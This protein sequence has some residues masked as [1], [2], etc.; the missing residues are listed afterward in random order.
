MTMTE[1]NP[2]DLYDISSPHAPR[3]YAPNPSKARLALSFKG[4]PF[5]TK[6]VDILDIPETRQGLKCP[7]TR[8]LDDGSDF[9]TLPI[10][11]NPV[12]GQTI[13]D[14]FDIA[15]YLD[16]TFPASSDADS[17]RDLFP[18]DSPVTKAILSYN[19]PAADTPF[20]APLTHIEPASEL[21]AA[22]A[23]FNRHVDAT[24]S[25]HLRLVAHRLPFNPATAEAVKALFAKRAHLSSWDDLAVP[26]EMRGS[27]MA[28]F[29][30]GVASLAGLWGRRQDGEGGKHSKG[31]FLEGERVTYADMIVGGWLNMLEVIMPPEEWRELRDWHGGVFGLL[32][33]ALQDRYFEFK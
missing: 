19:S 33:D 30:E 28:A 3:S 14:S 5:R 8:H 21:H 6:W 32:N 29:K 23:R 22:Y 20:Y 18:P 1:T 24:F 11:H 27:L 25:T 2:L 10:L 17:P 16:A 12:S 26:D 4:A 9:F 7:V 13:G 31:P 15:T